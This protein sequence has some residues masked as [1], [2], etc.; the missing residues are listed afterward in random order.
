MTHSSP[1]RRAF[2]R[3]LRTSLPPSG[4]EIAS[5]ASL[6]SPGLAE[7]L[8]RPAQQL[9]R[10]GR[11]RHRRQR[12]ARHHDRQPDP[13][14]APEQLLHEQ[15]QREPGRIADQVAVEERVVEALPRRGL[16]HLPRELLLAVVARRDGRT[17]SS[18]KRWV[19]A[20]RSWLG[21]REREVEAHFS[22]TA[23]TPWPPAAQIEISPR[24]EPFSSSS[25]ASVATIRPPVAA[26]GCP[27]ASEEPSTL[28]LARSIVPEPVLLPRGE[29]RQHLRGE[30]LV[31]LVEVEVLQRQAGLLE[32]PRHGVHGRHQQAVVAVD[33][34]DGRRLHVRD[35]REHGQ[36]AL[37]G[38]LVAGQ[39]HDGRAVGQRRRVAGGHRRVLALAEDGLELGEL[40]DARVRAQVLVALQARVGRDEVVEEA[41]VVGGGEA[42]VA[43]GGELVLVLA[44]DAFHSLAVIAACSPML[45]PV[46]GSALRGMSGTIWP[47]RSLPRSF[48]ALARA[49]AR[50]APPSAPCAGP[51]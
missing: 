16:D 3:R 44:G 37:G 17:T 11:L 25:L 29:R 51:R 32:Q 39:Q 21:G 8:G 6:R 36:L 10:R 47:G 7:A 1:S 48:S 2:V 28:S 18:A 27:A 15:R 34:V 49:L 45:R 41:A 4:S 46:R 26:N 50:G 42:L 5:A 33:V 35:V 30:R 20:I 9:L 24:P 40:L 12:Q 13:G 43:R 31:D 38:P 14:A 19:R 22:I 23:T